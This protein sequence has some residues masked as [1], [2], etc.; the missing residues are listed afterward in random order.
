MHALFVL[1]SLRIEEYLIAKA[2][3]SFARGEK[4]QRKRASIVIGHGSNKRPPWQRK[5][6]EKCAKR[7][8]FISRDGSPSNPLRDPRRKKKPP[9]LVMRKGKLRA[10]G[11]DDGREL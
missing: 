11:V 2:V 1:T 5:Y 7:D 10:P 8:Q 3:A 4:G 9:I 6:W